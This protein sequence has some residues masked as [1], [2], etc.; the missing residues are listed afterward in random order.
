MD[1]TVV[2][3]FQVLEALSGSGRPRGI[4]EMAGEL[5]MTKA[6]VHRLVRTLKELG[7]VSQVTDTSRYEPSLKLWQ[8]GASVVDRLDLTVVAAPVVRQLRDETHE[9]VQLAVRDG[10]TIVYVDKADSDRPVRATTQI[11]SRVPINCVSTGKAFLASCDQAYAALAFPLKRSTAATVVTRAA[12]DAQL[13]EFRKLGY[14]INRGEWRDGIW[15][16]ASAIRGSDGA[17]V[18]AIGIW[19]PE[20][21]F[22]GS[23]LKDCGSAVIRAAGEISTRM[24]CRASLRATEQSK[25][26]RH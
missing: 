18:G 4:T 6:N 12:V 1:K 20:D 9:S 22:Q 7:Y 15:G 16:V 10:D 14:A 13:K 5:G 2:K 8:L 11:G 19:G 24:G 3:A 23:A 25:G 21:R 26:T 17:V